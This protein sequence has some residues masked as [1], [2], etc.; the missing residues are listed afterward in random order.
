M[1][2]LIV[3]IFAL[4]WIGWNKKIETHNASLLC[5][6]RQSYS[7]TVHRAD[8]KQHPRGKHGTVYGCIVLYTARN[9]GR[10]FTIV[11]Q[12]EYGH[13]SP[14][15]FTVEYG[16]NKAVYDQ[17][18][19]EKGCLL[20]LYGAWFTEARN[21]SP[22]TRLTGIHSGDTDT[23]YNETICGEPICVNVVSQKER[24]SIPFQ[25]EQSCSA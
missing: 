9:P 13:K 20:W 10:W 24:V 12:R 11:F 18:C 3:N 25:F 7:A 5:L 2:T 4:R 16:T 6:G 14:A 17:K 8:M 1:I 22:R 23:D 21:I 19:R 15:I